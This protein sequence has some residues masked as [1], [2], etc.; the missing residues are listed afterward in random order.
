M[1]ERTSTSVAGRPP[2]VNATVGSGSGRGP[3]ELGG[4]VGGRRKFVPA[5]TTSWPPVHTVDGV[6]DAIVG[7]AMGGCYCGRGAF[8]ILGL[9]VGGCSFEEKSVH[10]PN[11]RLGSTRR[12]VRP[13]EH[14]SVGGIPIP[15]AGLNAYWLGSDR[16][17]PSAS[18]VGRV[19]LPFQDDQD[20][21]GSRLRLGRRS[22]WALDL[23]S[24]PV[25]DDP[26]TRVTKVV[27]ASTIVV[28]CESR[29]DWRL[30]E[31]DE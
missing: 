3:F 20:S 2:T 12:L 31:S 13:R 24:R 16:A 17:E 15:A 26:Q 18:Q 4:G 30:G 23:G 27:S 5:T 9:G 6:T 25:L 29:G 19:L 22:G 14:P 8:N 7:T 1:A 21:C 11:P 10:L 28:A